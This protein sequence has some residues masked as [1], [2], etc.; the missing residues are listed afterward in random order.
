MWEKFHKDN[1]EA[2]RYILQDHYWTIS[3]YIL[4]R[5]VKV[6]FP[7]EDEYCDIMNAGMEAVINTIAAFKKGGDEEFKSYCIPR[8][9][10]AMFDKVRSKVIKRRLGEKGEKITD[11]CLRSLPIGR[12]KKERG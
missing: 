12:Q 9:R 2:M 8:I 1:S 4:D 6:K 11:Q 3:N 10:R 7:D 5:I